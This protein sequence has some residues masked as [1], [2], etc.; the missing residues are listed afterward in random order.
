[1]KVNQRPAEL[2]QKDPEDFSA[3]EKE[4]AA[5]VISDKRKAEIATNEK[6]LAKDIKDGVQEKEDFI[7][8]FRSATSKAVGGV[9]DKFEAKREESAKK[10]A[11]DRK[12]ARKEEEKK[13]I[14]EG[15]KIDDETAK[16]A[17]TSK[18]DMAKGLRKAALAQ[19]EPEDF[20]ADEKE[21]AQAKLN[22]ARAAEVAKA[23]A[24]LETDLAKNEKDKQDFIDAFREGTSTAVSKVHKKVL[25]EAKKE[26][27]E[28]A[29]NIKKVADKNAAAVLKEAKDIDKKHKEEAKKQAE[30]MKKNQ[31]KEP[32]GDSLVQAEPEDFSADEKEAAAA[33]ISEKR[34]AEV[35]K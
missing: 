16:A 24:T 2:S 21:A 11:A 25:G 30:E 1:M 20:S 12:K 18:A 6:K 32:K 29:K 19:K 7:D 28:K 33:V 26:N 22:I 31:R 17:A 23:Q 8:A 27:K 3:D 35:S 10:N 5:A 15:K 13:N 14:A 9:Y 4:A 34:A